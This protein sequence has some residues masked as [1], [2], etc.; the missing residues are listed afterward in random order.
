[1]TREWARE[2]FLFNKDSKKLDMVGLIQKKLIQLTGWRLISTIVVQELIR[3]AVTISHDA[4]DSK[5]YE[6]CVQLLADE[7][8]WLDDDCK[9]HFLSKILEEV[10]S[11]PSSKLK[12]QGKRK[13]P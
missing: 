10:A 13:Q 7:G 2:E 8:D 6:E 4:K 5:E 11:Q 9:M 12:S 1:M 3:E